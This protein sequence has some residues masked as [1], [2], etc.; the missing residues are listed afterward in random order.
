[1]LIS[2]NI[3]N[4]LY[5]DKDI[6]EIKYMD[7]TVWSA[8]TKRYKFKFT[9]NNTDFKIYLNGVQMQNGTEISIDITSDR[10][11]LNITGV[12]DN[13]DIIAKVYINDRLEISKSSEGYLA[14]ERY[15]HIITQWLNKSSLIK[16]KVNQIIL[17]I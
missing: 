12:S 8:N 2:D 9:T 7:K 10:F 17:E 16:F 11:T 5:K 13:K 3:K 1:M 15:S 6:T 14:K 4:I